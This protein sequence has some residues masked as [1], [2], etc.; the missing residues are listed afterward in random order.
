[1]NVQHRACS[2]SDSDDE[3][4]SKDELSEC[5][6]GGD[7]GDG[8]GDDG[9]WAVAHT[10][11]DET[12]SVDAPS[13]PPSSALAN[14]CC[15]RPGQQRPTTEASLPRA[16]ITRTE[17]DAAAA[18]EDAAEVTAWYDEMAWLRQRAACRMQN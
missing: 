11:G 15:A 18:A 17:A 9:P 1:M 8:S 2:S 6:G 13:R 10:G 7:G 16:L 12:E 14:V 5:D 3:S 4:A